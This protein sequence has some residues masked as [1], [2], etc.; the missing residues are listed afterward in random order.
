MKFVNREAELEELEGLRALS[1]KKLFLTA[2]YGL[3]RVGKTRLLLEF[4]KGK[5]LYF[6][7]NRNKTSADLLREYE[8]IL[9]AGKILGELETLDSWDRF[10]EVITKRETPPVVFD[11][12][13]NFQFVEPSV[14]GILQKNVDLAEQGR[15]LIILSGSLMG[16]M[17]RMFQS[18]KEPLY[19]R[20]KK[21]RKLE[22]LGIKPCLELGSELKL[23][24]EDLVKLYCIFGGY[25]K[26]YVA[27][28]DYSLQGKSAED[29][30]GALLFA[31]GA[32]LEDEVNSMLS[33][34]F[35]GR[36]GVYYSILEAIAA[37]NTTMSAIAGYLNTPVTSITRQ[38]TELRDYFEFIEYE[39][40]YSGKKGAYRIRHPLMQFWFSQI[41]G[42]FSDYA[43]RRPEFMEGLKSG[44]DTA[45][46]RAFEEPARE[47]LVS[48]LKLTEARRQW[49][50]IA[51]AKKGEN[52]YEIDLIGKRQKET[53]AFEFKFKE[54]GMKEALGVL[55]ALR[56]KA[57]NVP[58]LPS[59]ARFGIVA[60]KLR[61]KEKIRDAGFLAYD[62]E[63]F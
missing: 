31:K 2:L 42:R 13:Q 6:F 35:G 44:L 41:Y 49:G 9:K 11:E 14:F 48:E 34:E 58:K 62:V 40:P 53:Y 55:E 57:K 51:G 47:F 15:G 3:R 16:L 50:K 43:A 20:I 46:G 4:L 30:I 33:Q 54:L 26:Y 60:K 52:T 10:V 37:G 18:S 28:E 21:G 12:F 29:I 1:K 56:E 5:G 22:P 63:D 36:S 45:F 19:G 7:V 8:G 25:P 17:K 23:R 24:R 32:P 39:K 38:M 59:D 27:I 61:E